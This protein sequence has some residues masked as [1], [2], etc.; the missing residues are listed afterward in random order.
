LVFRFDRAVRLFGEDGSVV[1]PEEFFG[2]FDMFL[3]AF[4]EARQDNENF[5]KRAEEEEKRLKQEAEV[6]LIVTDHSQLIV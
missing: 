2:I 1:Q 3:T 5:R 6:R 4:S